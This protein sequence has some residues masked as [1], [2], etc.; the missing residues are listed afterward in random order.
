MTPFLYGSRE[1]DKEASPD[2]KPQRIIDLDAFYMDK[3]P[4]TNEQYCLFL[5]ERNPSQKD[6]ENWVEL[7]GSFE[8]EK[9]RIAFEKGI[10]KVEPGFERFPVIDSDDNWHIACAASDSTRAGSDCCASSTV[11]SLL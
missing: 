9:C 6:R 7:S 2:E 5:N 4:V 11:C 1:D 8:K 10:Y 3:Y